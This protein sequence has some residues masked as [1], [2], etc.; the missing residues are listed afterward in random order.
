MTTPAVVVLLSIV[1]VLAGA[2][3]LGAMA[4]SLLVLQPK[5][6]RF[7][8]DPEKFEEFVASIAHGARWPVL[9]SLAVMGASGAG[10]W[11][12]SPPRDAAWTT[13]IATKLALFVVAA[14]IFCYT[15]WVLW[16]A[17]VFASPDQVPRFQRKFRRIGLTLIVI[18]SAEIA[19][20][21]IA[22]AG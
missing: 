11:L 6:A 4:Y 8:E 2:G 3:W 9:A 7:F 10:L 22:H 21:V 12:L 13:L 19:L 18:A 1:H 15:S 14:A 5:A 17:R 20:G 16:P